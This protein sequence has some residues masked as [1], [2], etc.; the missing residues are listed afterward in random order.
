MRA[1]AT[2]ASCIT[3]LVLLLSACLSDCARQSSNATCS[4]YPMSCLQQHIVT[5]IDN[6]TRFLFIDDGIENLPYACYLFHPH[7][8]PYSEV[9]VPCTDKNNG[10]PKNHD[11]GERWQEVCDFFCPAGQTLNES[12]TNSTSSPG[13]DQDAMCQ[14]Q[15]PDRNKA[16]C[17]RDPKA[18]LPLDVANRIDELTRC[19]LNVK[20]LD[21]PHACYLF[22]PH[23]IPREDR[24]VKCDDEKYG[25]TNNYIRGESWQHVCDYF[26]APTII[27]KS[28]LNQKDKPDLHPNVSSNPIENGSQSSKFVIIFAI[29]LLVLTIVFVFFI[30]YHRFFNTA[31]NRHATS[32]EYKDLV[33]QYIKQTLLKNL[34]QSIQADE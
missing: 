24:C 21:L 32:N 13:C 20:A 15:D 27:Y 22:H 30:C 2:M 29:I 33:L 4:R 17:R 1:A 9:C 19:C 18:C 8:V 12:S 5:R 6:L 31:M 26:C 11:R 16:L 14:D 28:R 25:C 3:I 34:F 7:T 23:S 10:C